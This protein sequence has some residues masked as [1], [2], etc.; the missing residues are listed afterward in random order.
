MSDVTL[1]EKLHSAERELKMRR[2]VYPRWVARQKMSQEQ[3]DHEI[4][5]MEAIVE[6]YRT[7]AEK[8][9]LPLFK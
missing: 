3:A 6:D 9:P 1:A 4:R 2:Q 5:C 7:L 8:E